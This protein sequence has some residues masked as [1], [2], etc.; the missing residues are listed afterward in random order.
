MNKIS[1]KKTDKKGNVEVF[2]SKI[3]ACESIK[4]NRHGFDK[5]LEKGFDK[6]G[7]KWE[8]IEK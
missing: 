2:R 7:N 1:V 8:K 4:T 3:K 6:D 5:I